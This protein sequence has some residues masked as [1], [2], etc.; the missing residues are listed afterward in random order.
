MSTIIVV[1]RQGVLDDVVAELAKYRTAPKILRAGNAG[2]AKKHLL[3]QNPS[4]ILI[5]D[6]VEGGLEILSFVKSKPN[7]REIHTIYFI[8]Y[9][10]D[11][12]R[13][14]PD[15][16]QLYVKGVYVPDEVAGSIEHIL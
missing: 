5:E 6:T 4:A 16:D 14:T 8:T 1:D 15:M 12:N 11:I 13:K 2:E 3:L 7:L 10:E 9:E